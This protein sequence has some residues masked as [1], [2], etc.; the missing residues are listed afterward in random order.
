[1]NI[2]LEGLNW[3]LT[4]KCVCYGVIVVNDKYALVGGCAVAV[5]MTMKVY[6]DGQTL[7]LQYLSIT[8]NVN[9]KL[10]KHDWRIDT[11]QYII[12]VVRFRLKV[13]V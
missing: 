10:A 9:D 12:T 6:A 4:I 1:M 2:D 5:M 7:R 11:V 8:V 3:R 13:N